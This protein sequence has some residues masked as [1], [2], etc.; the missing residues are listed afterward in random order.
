VDAREERMAR[1]EALLRKVNERIHEVGERLQVLPDDEL[2]EFRCECGRPKC[3]DFV[4]LTA[5][6]YEHVRSD[7]DRFAV[8]L[9][10]E[11]P[12]IERVVKRTDR[13]LVVDKRPEAESLVGADGRPDSGS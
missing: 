11:D 4:S 9:G 5:H 1:N 10:H 13:Y 6:E 7:D 12:E 3:D 8:V 2:L